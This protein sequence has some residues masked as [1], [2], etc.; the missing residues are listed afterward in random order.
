MNPVLK[1]SDAA[2]SNELLS[3]A[4]H[5]QTVITITNEAVA[6]STT[7]ETQGRHDPDSYARQ[8]SNER[9]SRHSADLQYA[10]LLARE[11][12]L[13][14]PSSPMQGQPG[15]LL[16]ITQQPRMPYVPD[17]DDGRGGFGASDV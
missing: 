5:T 9:G 16:D 7:S 14:F 12:G 3:F 1:L 4:N 6:R 15:S 8:L 2:A 13:N 10:Q 11:R 17:R